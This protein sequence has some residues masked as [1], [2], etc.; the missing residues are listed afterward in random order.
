[1]LVKILS[2]IALKALLTIQ[3]DMLLFYRAIYQYHFIFLRSDLHT[4]GQKFAF[5]FWEKALRVLLRIG[6]S[7]NELSSSGRHFVSP[8][9]LNRSHFLYVVWQNVSLSRTH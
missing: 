6:F 3:V 4:K 7:L 2:D 5:T 8:F 9:R 1:M